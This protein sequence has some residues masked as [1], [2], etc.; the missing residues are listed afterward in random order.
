M[1]PAR[2]IILAST[3]I[4]RQRLLQRLGLVF[5]TRSPGVD[6]EPLPGELPEALARRLSAAKAAA[7][8]AEHPDALVIGSD[9]VAALGDQLLGK[10]GTFAN[11]CSQL[12]HCSGQRVQF[13]TAVSLA[14]GGHLLGQRCVPTDVVFR[15]LSDPEI[16]DY[17]S[18][19]NPLD[20]AGSFRWEGL[21]IVLFESLQSLDPTALEGLPLIETSSLLLEAGI[22]LLNRVT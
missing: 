13:F 4:Y 3:S 5:E 20:C 2:P 8:T 7:I 18:R 17:V 14:K 22:S 15:T 9:Q 19:E 16:S 21:G 10:L 6:E 11:A 12:R 1:N